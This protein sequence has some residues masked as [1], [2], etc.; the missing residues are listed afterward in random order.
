[1]VTIVFPGFSEKNRDWVIETANK[2]SFNYD[3]RPV[4]WDHWTD[5]SKK[6]DIPKKVDQLLKIIKKDSINLVAKSIGTLVASEVLMVDPIRVSKVILC[7]IPLND[8]NEAEKEK[9]KDSLK[10]FPHDRVIC[11]QNR[12]DPHGSYEQVV[13]FFEDTEIKIVPKERDDHE[14]PYFDEFESFLGG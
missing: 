4:F 3:S 7:G 13:K 2:L 11:F 8:L 6:F 10:H 14:Y 9:I 1:M 5:P 12:E